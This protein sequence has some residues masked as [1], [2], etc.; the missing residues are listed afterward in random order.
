MA[1]LFALAPARGQSPAATIAEVN[2]VLR[3]PS[4]SET[5]R[6]V[7][8]GV[9]IHSAA[10]PRGVF[11]QQG[12]AGV[13][14]RLARDQVLPSL[15][16]ECEVAAEARFA[17]PG[18]DTEI[19][20]FAIR[21]IGHPGL[22]EPA[23]CTLTETVKGLYNRR[24]VQVEG[25]VLHV[26]RQFGVPWLM[27][28]DASGAAMAGVHGWPAGWSAEG[29]MGKQVRVRGV[30]AGVWQ[31]PLRCSSPEEITVIGPAAPGQVALSSVA[32]VAAHRA[33][34]EGESAVPVVLTATCSEVEPGARRFTLHAEGVSIPVLSKVYDS[35]VPLPQVGESVCI[36]GILTSIGGQNGIHAWSIDTAGAAQI[37]PKSAGG[38]NEFGGPKKS[39][40][41]VLDAPV[42]TRRLLVT[43][44]VLYAGHSGPVT[45]LVVRDST[46]SA[47]IYGP[48]GRHLPLPAPGDVVEVEG[49]RSSTRPLSPQLF[50]ATWR[51]IGHEALPEPPLVPMAE[52]MS[53]DYDGRLARMRGRVV[54]YETFQE[55]GQTVSRV[56]VRAGDVVTYGNF[57][58]QEFAPAPAKVGQLVELRGV[59][60]VSRTAPNVVRTFSV[61]LNS[62]ADVRALPE[63]ALWEDPALRPWF[64]GA[65]LALLAVGAWVFLLRRQVRLRTAK[66]AARESELERAL[67]REQELGNLKTSFISM[68]SHEFRTPLNVIVTSSDI[69]ARYMDRLP[70]EER[71]EHL[72]SIQKSIKRMAGM[73]EDVLLLGRFDA[74]QQKL[75]PGELL[76]P[77][78]C[79]RFVDEMRSATAG[80]CHI[81]LSLG[82]FE[83]MVRADE[84][85]LRHILANLI[86]NAVKYSKPG[87][88]VNLSVE[89]SGRDAVFRVQDHGLGIPA[90]DQKLLFDAFQRGGNVAHISGTG[91]G[92]VVVKRGVELHGGTIEFVSQEGTGTT[93]TVRLPLFEEV[94]ESQ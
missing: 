21:V 65:G 45:I 17:G 68:V 22:P 33:P 93:F 64:I 4:K 86:S 43:G 67:A 34:A 73:M 77:A 11:L 3:S 39:V 60:N 94:I 48:E 9:V 53:V 66:L 20:A 46:G 27:L 85:V 26:T 2:R 15:G 25:T 36:S 58:G 72:A 49:G 35:S 38:R 80:R 71:A 78:W 18:P 51:V 61:Q 8:R 74:G 29:L 6:M 91:L 87:D 57:I 23:P 1:L 56:W 32:E 7:F 5:R 10:S 40:R 54:D 70:A 14:V 59:C 90:E 52:A 55:R 69:L 24:F 16:D 37:P 42:S 89:R 83:P 79:R 41:E 81:D 76:L 92:L 31:Q 75:Q 28:C 44:T 30:S 47:Y 63:P 12:E 84:S 82:E 19:D 13:F 62:M 88:G 50:D